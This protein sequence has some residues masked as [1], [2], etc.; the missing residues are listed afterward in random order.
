MTNNLNLFFQKMA[1][2]SELHNGKYPDP[3]S[4]L[5]LEEEVAKRER[6]EREA[7]VKLLNLNF[8]VFFTFNYIKLHRRL[9]RPLR[10][11]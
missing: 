10:S 8:N 1:K 11:S 3:Y 4:R 9:P 2:W 7:K 6:E 5:K